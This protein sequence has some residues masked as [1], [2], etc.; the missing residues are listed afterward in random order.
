MEFCVRHSPAHIPELLNHLEKISDKSLHRL[1]VLFIKRQLVS[2]CTT[3][4]LKSVWR[5]YESI[6]ENRNLDYEENEII[7]VMLNNL[8]FLDNT[9]YF[10][11]GTLR[12]LH[13][14]K[15]F[16][17]L[18][19]EGD[20]TDLDAC[21]KDDS[22]HDASFLIMYL[23]DV[24]NDKISSK[25]VFDVLQTLFPWVDTNDPYTEPLMIKAI[26]LG[27]EIK[28]GTVTIM[29]NIINSMDS[30]VV[31]DAYSTEF[32]THPEIG[33][34]D[35]WISIRDL[36]R[37]KKWQNIGFSKSEY[38]CAKVLCD[39]LSYIQENDTVLKKLPTSYFNTSNLL[40]KKCEI[41]RLDWH[42]IIADREK[43]SV[44]YFP[45]IEKELIKKINEPPVMK[46]EDYECKI[47]FG[48][49][50]IFYHLLC[51]HHID[52]WKKLYMETGY[53]WRSKINKLSDTGK[54]STASKKILLGCLMPYIW[55]NQR[56]NGSISSRNKA[57]AI[58]NIVNLEKRLT[59]LK[60]NLKR[61]ILLKSMDADTLIDSKNS[62][63]IDGA[64]Y[65]V[66][67]F[68]IIEI[69]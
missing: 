50:T 64:R 16:H 62:S 24:A 57:I 33:Y 65:H 29:T 60:N 20:S 67:E 6:K 1:G 22:Q 35:G 14:A 63:D 56:I 15:A 45:N 49:G 40:L 5:K 43:L 3:K 17:N 30:D 4:F 59:E 25:V 19:I 69:D 51:G 31:K 12:F 27:R 61:N 13:I 38:V 18:L 9:Y 26:E 2:L 54:I 7:T 37:S 47:I 68:K 53:S 11:H 42:D 39:I 10:T 46:P 28:S 66:V 21:M 52:D 58:G 8:P 44:Q 32:M 48:L 55:E 34:N 23:I 41:E 36:L